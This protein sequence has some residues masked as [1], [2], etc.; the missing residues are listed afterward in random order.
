MLADS[1]TFPGVAVVTRSSDCQAARHLTSMVGEMDVST[2]PRTR[3]AWH[4]NERC[5]SKNAGLPDSH[6]WRRLIA[7]LG[8][9]ETVS[10]LA[11]L[12]DSNRDICV[13][14]CDKRI[15]VWHARAERM[16]RLSRATLKV[17]E[18]QATVAGILRL[19][20]GST[21]TP[22]RLAGE[23]GER[24]ALLTALG[25][26]G[27]RQRPAPVV[28]DLSVHP[29][30]KFAFGAAAVRPAA[31]GPVAEDVLGAIG[32]TKTAAFMTVAQVVAG[33]QPVRNVVVVGA[34]RRLHFVANGGPR[35]LFEGLEGQGLACERT[36]RGVRLVYEKPVRSELVEVLGPLAVVEA[37][38]NQ[39]R[40]WRNVVEQRRQRTATPAGTSVAPPSIPVVRRTAFLKRPKPMPVSTWQEAEAVACAWMREFGFKDAHLTGSGADAGVDVMSRRAVAQVKWKLSGAIGRPDVQRLLGVAQAAKSKPVFFSGSGYTAE[41]RSWAEMHGIA[42]F[43]LTDQGELVPITTAARKMARV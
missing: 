3:A 17:A 41:A 24:R 7:E 6:I 13:A 19:S 43:T 34:G 42:A 39:V 33:G 20:D 23:L 2:D 10:H 11:I 14:V 27:G 32:T 29:K 18:H 15:I 16:R 22:I 38:E 8:L 37:I 25:L 30:T 36:S 26:P 9:D 35:P 12:T 5:V 21:K 4:A 28:L 31:T 1:A 40:T